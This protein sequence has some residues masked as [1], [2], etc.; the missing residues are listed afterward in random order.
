MILAFLHYW[1]GVSLDNACQIMNFFTGLNL[2]KGQADSLL[3]QLANDWDEQYDTIAQLI[4]LQ[5]IVYI[6]ETSLATLGQWPWPRNRL[7]GIVDSIAVQVPA[8][9]GFD[10]LFA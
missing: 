3:S 7:A 4:A 5:M 10:I 9:V 6:D 8:A 1:I 2:S